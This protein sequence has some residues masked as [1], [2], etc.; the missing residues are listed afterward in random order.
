MAS[1]S[2]ALFKKNNLNSY[3]MCNRGPSDIMN[4]KFYEEALKYWSELQEVK[5]P[6][7]EIIYN[8]TIWDNKYIAIQNTPGKKRVSSKY[9]IS[10]ETMGSFWTTTK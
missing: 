7:A 8:Q 2:L 4:H 5:V 10:Y 3:F 9:V 1:Y 6:T